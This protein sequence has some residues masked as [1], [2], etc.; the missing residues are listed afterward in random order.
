MSKSNA[1]P[2]F[3]TTQLITVP[4]LIS[5][6]RSILGSSPA[7]ALHVEPMWTL[8]DAEEEQGCP[9][10][11]TVLVGKKH[12]RPMHLTIFEFALLC[13]LSRVAGITIVTN[14]NFG[15]PFPRVYARMA[16]DGAPEDLTSIRRL[17]V[18]AKANEATK[19]RWNQN[20]YRAESTYT[21]E[22]PHPQKDARKVALGHIER[23]ARQDGKLMAATSLARED[24]MRRLPWAT[25]P[26]DF[27]IRAHMSNI[28]SLFGL[29]D[30]LQSGSVSDEK[31]T[32]LLSGGSPLPEEWQLPAV[33]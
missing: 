5:E 21:V 4:R 12:K 33:A 10:A 9:D 20:D 7:W 29:V 2:A 16:I 22:H 11:V 32:N 25:L 31:L 24:A 8:P 15:K 1:F 14:S 26:D 17:I 13:E 3:E 19:A 18:G 6:W 27:H 23:L 30:A 28:H